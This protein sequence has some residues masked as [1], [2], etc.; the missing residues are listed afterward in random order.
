MHFGSL[1]CII[2]F[3]R[4]AQRTF[5]K[6]FDILQP[7]AHLV[8]KLKEQWPRRFGTPAL[9]GRLTEPPAL[10]QLGLCYASFGFHVRPSVGFVRTAMKALFAGKAK[11]GVEPVR[12]RD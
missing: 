2:G 8:A 11:W 9:Q 4:S 3:C 6:R 1:V 5:L 12:S 7:V 10:S